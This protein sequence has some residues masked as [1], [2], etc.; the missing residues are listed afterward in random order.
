[1]RLGDQPEICTFPP[2]ETG[3][4]GSERVLPMMWRQRSA[5]V[6]RLVLR[7]AAAVVI[8]GERLAGVS[9]T[10]SEPLETA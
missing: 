3:G 6:L 9:D 8:S 7:L 5:A 4:R 2:L 10:A 1:M